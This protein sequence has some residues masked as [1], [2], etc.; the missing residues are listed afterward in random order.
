[1]GGFGRKQRRWDAGGG[2]VDLN[3]ALGLRIGGNI[4]VQVVVI[5]KA[6]GHR[7]Q[8]RHCWH[9]E[10]ARVSRPA[11]DGSARDGSGMYAHTGSHAFASGSTDCA[12]CSVVTFVRFAG[13]RVRGNTGR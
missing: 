6:K 8:V 1:M 10:V 5:K 13:H 11:R 12:L 4:G 7:H 3:I 2:C 9:D